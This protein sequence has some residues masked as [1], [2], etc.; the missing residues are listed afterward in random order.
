MKI[1]I[2]ESK[3]GAVAVAITDKRRTPV[4]FY[5]P[6]DKADQAMDAAAEQYRLHCAHEL[7]EGAP[8]PDPT[9]TPE[10]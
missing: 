8:Q 5:M 1:E 7:A 4:R 9:E 2:S 6:A 3:G 10:G